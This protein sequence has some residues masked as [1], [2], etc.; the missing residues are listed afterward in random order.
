LGNLLAFEHLTGLTIHDGDEDFFRFSIPAGQTGGKSHSVG[1][2]FDE[3]RGDLNFELRNAAGTTVVRVPT[4]RGGNKIIPLDGLAAGTYLIRVGDQDARETNRYTLHVDAPL[5]NQQPVDDWTVMI[6]ITAS[7]LAPFAFDDMN[8]MEIA[9]AGLPESVNIVVLYDQSALH[10]RFPT[11]SGTQPAWGG[12]G[13]A[14]I[15]PDTNREVIATD[16]DLGIGER[17]T[18]DPNSLINFVTWAIDAAPAEHYS[19]ILWDHGQGV[20]GFNFD[21]A[22]D[23]PA[24]F[25]TAAELAIALQQLQTTRGFRADLL[26][27]DSCNMA[28]TELADRFAPFAETIV[29]SQ[30][31]IA[32]TGYDYATIFGPLST[33]PNLTT[34]ES[35]ASAIKE[36]FENQ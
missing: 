19:L 8:E 33:R 23:S 25:L 3:G 21:N 17:N 32:G 16:F 5:N 14:V 31:N 13:H 27:F 34:V 22:D 15:R 35:F 12:T 2:E 29:A 26:A 1:I 18:G 9:A 7:D 10:E 20:E 24:D 11:G 28:M 36:S 4:T 30:E 6:Y